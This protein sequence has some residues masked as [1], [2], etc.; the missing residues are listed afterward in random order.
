MN[1][2]IVAYPLSAGY[3]DRFEVAIDDHPEYVALQELRARSVLGTV[4]ALRAMR[5]RIC[6]LPIEDPASEAL[7]PILALVG[8]LGR[9]KV[10]VVVRHDLSLERLSKG[11]AWREALGVLSGSIRNIVSAI[12][13]RQ[14]LA[15]LD[16]TPRPSRSLGPG[17]RVLYLSGNLWFGVRAGGSVGH[18]AGVVNALSRAGL[19][20]DLWSATTPMMVRPPARTFQLAPLSTFGIPM[21][22]NYISFQ[23]RMVQQIRRVASPDAYS[24]LYQR[25]SVSNYAG[26]VLSRLLRIPLVLEHNG[27]E[28]WIARKWGR[29]LR[30]ERLAAIAE[31]VSLRHAHLIVTVSEVLRDYIVS[32][33]IE[34]ERVVWYPNGIDP[35][36]FDP[37]RFTADQLNALRARHGLDADDVVVTFV[38]TFGRWH[39]AEV[40]ARAIRSLVDGDRDWLVRRRVRFLFV[41]EGV[42]MPDVREALGPESKDMV[43]FAGLV[44]QESA[45]LY[46]VASDILAAPHVPNSDGSPFFG[47]PT[48]LF[49]YMAAGKAILASDLD[50]IGDV[51]RPALRTDAL[52]VDGPDDSAEELGVLAVPGD[53]GDIRRGLRFL[54]DHPEWRARLGANA[55][56]T[57]LDRYTWDHHVAAILDRLAAVSRRAN[58]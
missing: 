38:G 23:R 40:L 50:Q 2:A 8:V 45:P 42:R 20:V 26:V 27:S 31:S 48:K 55:R 53:E 34:P 16:G 58:R 36:I 12:R 37:S 3:R 49:E 21:E 9:T 33:G 46:L 41:G 19:P 18:T 43:R 30:F 15:R 1:V 54:V 13:A 57:A 17:K 56:R 7:L 25:M 5:G 35:N 44:P 47:S 28:V 10:L 52:P 11:H 14:E 4:R 51:I 29:P 22:L 24:F 32:R 6:Y 39:G